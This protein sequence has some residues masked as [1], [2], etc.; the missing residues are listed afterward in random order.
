MPRNDEISTNPFSEKCSKYSDYFFRYL[1]IFFSVLRIREII[2]GGGGIRTDF[3]PLG[4]AGSKLNTGKVNYSTK[5][6]K[7]SP[8]ELKNHQIY[9]KTSLKKNFY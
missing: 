5:V 4:N 6:I 3:L 7:P 1:K 9:L 2:F 8:E